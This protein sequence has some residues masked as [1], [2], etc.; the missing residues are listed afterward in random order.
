[1]RNGYLT[2]YLSL[3][4][5]LILSF[6]L[7][8]VEGARMSAIR[9]STECV[10][11]IG[12]N[13]VLAEY[14]RELLEQ[15]D[16][17]FVDMS[18]GTA[19]P[20]IVNT[21]EHLRR[22]IQGNFSPRTKAVI[23][24]RDWLSLSAE[25]SEITEYCLASDDAGGVMQR[26]ALLYMEGSTVQ[27]MLTKLAGRMTQMETLGLDTGDVE[28]KRH[29][30]QAQI[31]AVELPKEEDENGAL[32]EISLDNP[33]DRVNASRHLGVLNLVLKDASGISSAAVNTG[34]YLSHR[35]ER[36]RSA[37]VLTGSPLKELRRNK[38][39]PSGPAARLLFD[40]YLFEKC[41]YYGQLKKNSNLKYQIEY[42]LSGKNSDWSN[43]ESVTKRLLLWREAANVI[44]IL[45]DSAKCAEAEALA[46]TLT[47][48]LR[49]P[50][51]KDP[52]KYSILFAWAYVESLWDVRSLL[53]GGRVP[54][55]KTAADWRTGIGQVKDFN[56]A[57]V[58]DGGSGSG[59]TYKDYL[60]IMLFL[61]D[62][63]TK[64]RRTMDIME[65]DIRQTPGNRYFCMDACFD[66]FTAEI[67]VSS[68]FGYRYD[69]KR[70]YGYE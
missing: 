61:E 48:V 65:M 7:T 37:P 10:A 3:S 34:D 54:L 64:N 32:K 49:V 1:M 59:L 44:Y 36:G 40:E 55:I 11:D 50:A 6:V 43:L 23:S 58:G 69:I 60:G 41:G 20:D 17:F 16:L 52:V 67:S 29:G 42:I 12:M 62:E 31:D 18:Y 5:S 24:T 4:L 56:A 25:K 19:Y 26:Q 66:A 2:V 70:C 14:N 9:M 33:A 47:A 8:L 46:L 57:S 38:E 63:N 53:N 68:G 51:L 21:E 27:G 39:I 30:I 35:M 28:I 45:S 22:Y 15:Y 13:S